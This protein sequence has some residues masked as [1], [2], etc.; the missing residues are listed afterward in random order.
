MRHNPD[1]AICVMPAV[2]SN[3]ISSYDSD[4]ACHAFERQ[5]TSSSSDNGVTAS[6]SESSSSQ[7]SFQVLND[8][9]DDGSLEVSPD[10][11][12][13]SSRPRRRKT[14]S[15]LSRSANAQDFFGVDRALRGYIESEPASI[16]AQEG[17]FE[18]E[19]LEQSSDLSRE[20]LLP[21]EEDEVDGKMDDLKEIKPLEDLV[22]SPYS[23]SL[24]LNDSLES[25]CQCI[26]L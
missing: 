22:T 18:T 1:S 6:L 7:G 2:V 17:Q 11:K 13:H 9:V 15:M 26:I 14:E 21:S 19:K 5:R 4:P 24:T 3:E 23:S 20:L 16:Q 25:K 8:S 10:R 12:P